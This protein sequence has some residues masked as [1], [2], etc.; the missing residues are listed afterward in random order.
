M[1]SIAGDALCEFSTVDGACVL[2]PPPL[3]P[4]ARRSRPPWPFVAGK[5]GRKQIASD[6]AVGEIATACLHTAAAGAGR[7]VRE[8]DR[9][10]RFFY[11]TGDNCGKFILNFM[12]KLKISKY[13]FFYFIKNIEVEINFIFF[14]A[15]RP[16]KLKVFDM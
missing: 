2:P 14:D 16:V 9:V 6:F 4:A 15:A 1:D 13:L 3:L 12:R 10:N 11:V 8:K 7:G 5:Y